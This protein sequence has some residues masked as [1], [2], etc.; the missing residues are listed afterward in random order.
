MQGWLV[1]CIKARLHNDPGLR[2]YHLD[3]I[4]LS[5]GMTYA[6]E[7]TWTTL[8]RDTMF[9]WDSLSGTAQG[10]VRPLRGPRNQESPLSGFI[11]SVDRLFYA[12]AAAFVV[13]LLLLALS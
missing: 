3:T 5:S 7:S 9:T 12:A 4:V 8:E 1:H 2:P 11:V 13:S 6:P 10:S